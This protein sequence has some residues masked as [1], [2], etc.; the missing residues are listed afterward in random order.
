MH[1]QD[2]SPPGKPGNLLVTGKLALTRQGPG[3]PVVPIDFTRRNY[4]WYHVGWASLQE[5]TSH[6][7]Q[8]LAAKSCAPNM[9]KGPLD[10]QEEFPFLVS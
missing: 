4:I 1:W 8:Q 10:L 2:G 6:L 3:I 9:N 7:C 5:V